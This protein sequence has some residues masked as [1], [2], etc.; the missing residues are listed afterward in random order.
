MR[1]ARSSAW[2]VSARGGGALSRVDLC[3]GGGGVSVQEVSVQGVYVREGISVNRI[4]DRCKNITLPQTSFAGG[5]N[6]DLI[7]TTLFC[8]RLELNLNCDAP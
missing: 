6:A 4:T 2:G 8:E 3:Q 7:F 5:N 1:T